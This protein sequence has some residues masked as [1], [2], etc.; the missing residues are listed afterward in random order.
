MK[1]LTVLM[2]QSNR[3]FNIP[4]ATPRAFEFLENSPL[5]GLK[6]CSNA[7]TR[8]CLRRRSGGLFHWQRLVI[9]LI[10]TR[11]MI[12]RLVI[13][14]PTPYEWWSNSLALLGRK[15]R[16]MPGVCQGGCWSFDLTGTLGELWGKI[17]VLIFFNY[18]TNIV[19]CRCIFFCE[20]LDVWKS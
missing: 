9:A 19:Q 7:P 18:K 4:R 5:P 2:Y 11:N 15:G 16:Q 8:T 13:K 20:V 1:L 17:S 10:P 12:S 14:F 6:C 3:S